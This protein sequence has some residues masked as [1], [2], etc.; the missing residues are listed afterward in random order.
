MRKIFY[1][2]PI[3]DIQEVAEQELGRKLTLAEIRK[4]E[5]SIVKRIA[6]YDAIANAMYKC[7]PEE[8]EKAASN[9][10]FSETDRFSIK[11]TDKNVCPTKWSINQT[12]SFRRIIYIFQI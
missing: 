3:D 2:R 6:W 5:E 4:V 11:P 8:A 10:D 9:F 1:S 12:D 7:F